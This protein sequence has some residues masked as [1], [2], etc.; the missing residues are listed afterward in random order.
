MKINPVIIAGGSGTR[1]WPASRSGY[2][3]Q[4]AKIHSDYSL[5]QETLLRVK[6]DQFN[7][8]I[9]V[10]NRE[11]RFLV[12]NQA[13]ELDMD[14]KIILEPEGR[15]TAAAISLAAH[16]IGDDEIILVMSS[17][18]YIEDNE[19]FLSSTTKALEILNKKTLVTFGVRP[20]S[21]NTGYGYINI[22]D[23]NKDAFFIKS[24][25]EKPNLNKAKKYYKS[26][27][28]FWSIGI[29][30]FHS[31]TILKELQKYEPEIYSH[32]Q[33]SILKSKLDN[34]FIHIDEDEF[35]KCKNISIDVAVMENTN[36]GQLIPLDCNWKDLGTWDQVYEVDDKKD[37]DLNSKSGNIRTID[38]KRNIFYGD[39]KLIVS[40]GLEDT[41]ICDT[42]DAL[43]VANKDQIH[44]LKD[45]VEELKYEDCPQ[46][47]FHSKV[48]RPWG[49]YE[50][51][52]SGKSFQVKR[53]IVNPGAKLSVQK[54]HKRSE[55]WV[56]VQGKAEV[57]K[58][59][60]TFLLEENESTYIPVGTIH[61]L[62][63]PGD[64]PL[65]LIEVQ[66]GSYLGEDDIVRFEDIY[67]RV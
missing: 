22:G 61:A 11:H 38:S 19:K 50:C 26:K 34:S 51:I 43:L 53:I 36:K 21:P 64:D 15:N 18:A 58:G 6:N 28:Y 3:K 32:T 1:L 24:Y 29:F 46:L 16:F 8:P 59:E 2:P 12:Q 13:N 67:G 62:K 9:V 5:I 27:D 7:N 54:H 63:N 25:K 37:I 17:D 45:V 47:E 41:V 56:V 14:V 40:I 4:F 49:S 48:Y 35:K 39:D 60:D 20:S 44:K 65:H 57:L 31:D 66:T 33:E 52:D 30:M 55:H 23:S 42:K 10:C